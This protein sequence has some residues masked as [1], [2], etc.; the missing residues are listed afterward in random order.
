MNTD[1]IHNIEKLNEKNIELMD[2]NKYLFNQY[3]KSNNTINEINMYYK[4]N[5]NLMKKNK[6]F[7]KN[8]K[9]LNDEQLNNNNNQL[10]QPKLRN[11]DNN[12][13]FKQPFNDQQFN[14]QQFNDQQPLNN[15]PNNNNNQFNQQNLR[16]KINDNQPIKQPIIKQTNKKIYDTKDLNIIKKLINKSK[17]IIELLKE[18]QNQ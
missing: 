14:N 17:N 15:Q 3:D 11:F 10:N 9:D 18:I 6:M 1:I 4:N 12:K 2:E 7:I 13:Q 5:H 8:I 16:K